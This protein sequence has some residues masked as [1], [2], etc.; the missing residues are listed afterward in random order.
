LDVAQYLI[1]NTRG[2]RLRFLCEKNGDLNVHSLD[3]ILTNDEPVGRL[4]ETKEGIIEMLGTFVHND[5]A[6]EATRGLYEMEFVFD[7]AM[8]Q[9]IDGTSNSTSFHDTLVNNPEGLTLDLNATMD[10]ELSLPAGN[11]NTDGAILT[12]DQTGTIS[13]TG[14]AMR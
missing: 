12:L 14:A 13:G 5:G 3:V 6:I 7:G 8:M 1:R 9:F 11:V 2:P 4:V 10:G